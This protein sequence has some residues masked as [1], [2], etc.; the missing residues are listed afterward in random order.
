MVFISSVFGY[1]RELFLQLTLYLFMRLDKFICK[2]TSL[3]LLQ[4]REAIENGQVHVNQQCVLH[5]NTQVHENKHIS[6]AGKQL[7]ARPSRYI[8]I[9]K[10]AGCVCSNVDEAYPSVFTAVDLPL[11][12]QLHIAGRLD[13]DTTGLVLATDD[14]RWS[15]SITRPEQHCLKVYRVNL[16]KPLTPQAIQALETGLQLQGE[17]QPTRPAVVKLISDKQ[18]LLSISEGKF[19]QVKRMLA[20]VGNRVT[21]L[22]RQQ[23]ADICLNV[24]PASWRELSSAEVACI[25]QVESEK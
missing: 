14:G 21:A 19:H 20:A 15:F 9:N 16:S 7:F 22:H 18:I 23:I 2:S 10:P 4:A 6:L 5:V 8:M 3:S 24:E 13:A 25:K 1:T 12:E 11:D 17:P